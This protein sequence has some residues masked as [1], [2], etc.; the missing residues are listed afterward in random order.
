MF[1]DT[2]YS[3]YFH[4]HASPTRRIKTQHATTSVINPQPP[5]ILTHTIFN[6]YPF[7][8]CILYFLNNL[9]QNYVILII[10]K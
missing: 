7:V 6:Y 4:Q 9:K 2:F 5:K 3:Q 10:V 1:Y 8:A